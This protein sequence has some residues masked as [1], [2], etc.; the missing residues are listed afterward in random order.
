MLNIIFL[1]TPCIISVF[2]TL[3]FLFL[4]LIF[5]FFFFSSFWVLWEWLFGVQYR[6]GKMRYLASEIQNLAGFFTTPRSWVSL[7]PKKGIEQS[8]DTETRIC[9]W[10]LLFLCEYVLYIVALLR[11]KFLMTIVW[12]KNGFRFSY[13]WVHRCIEYFWHQNW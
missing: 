12:Q 2:E 11:G 1:S 10:W 3:T 5:F 9:S 6:M 4:F 13:T 7:G 8:R